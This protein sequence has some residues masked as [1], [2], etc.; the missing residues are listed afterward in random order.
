ME[1]IP[2]H[3]SR[4]PSGRHRHMTV[5]HSTLHLER[6]HKGLQLDN[7]DLFERELNIDRVHAYSIDIVYL[8]A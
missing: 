2:A 4:L 8:E 3:V 6:A 5:S 7:A 1:G